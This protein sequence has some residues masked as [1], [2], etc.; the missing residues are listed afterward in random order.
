MRKFIVVILAFIVT[1]GVA[2]GASLAADSAADAAY[3]D[4]W[5]TGDNGGYGFGS[6]TLTAAG[7]A[8]WFTGSSTNNGGPPTPFNEGIDS[9]TNAFGLWATAGGL[10][11]AVRPLTGGLQVNQSFNIAMDNGWVQT[12]GTVGFGLQNAAGDNLWEWYYAGFNGGDDYDINQFGGAQPTLYQYTERGMSLSFSLT[13]PTNW[14]LIVTSPERGTS[15][16]TGYLL[17]QAGG[18]TITQ[19]RGF[20]SNGGP[21]SNYDIFYNSL[22]VIPEPSTLALIS[23]AVAGL[24]A[25]RRRR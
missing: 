2:L 3:N 4:G 21:G 8:G 9:P 5:T 7:T 22:A 25:C 23:L 6:W 10:M 24:L 16:Y 12:N 1:T 14:S 11:T 19:F 20:N 15:N 17:S 18:Q 13:G